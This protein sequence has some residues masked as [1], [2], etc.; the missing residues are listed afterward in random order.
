MSVCNLHSAQW[1]CL[2]QFIIYATPR[3][4][5]LYYNC[6]CSTTVPVICTVLQWLCLF[7]THTMLQ[8][9]YFNCDCLC[10]MLQWLCLFVIH[11]MP[12][13]LYFNCDCLCSM[14]QWLCLFVIHTMPQWL[15]FNCDCLCSTT[16]S[17]CILFSATMVVP[18]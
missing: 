17:V 9:V 11:T 13:W 6:L 1:L 8:W 12:Q 4:L 7:V 16:G 2:F 5:Y 14:L 3:W 18:V 10:S 15:Y